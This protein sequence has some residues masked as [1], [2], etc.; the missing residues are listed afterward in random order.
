MLSFRVFA[1]CQPDWSHRPPAVASTRRGVRISPAPNL[2]GS[3]IGA[4]FPASQRPSIH[5]T[6]FLSIASGLFCTMGACNPFPFN[7]LRT[8]SIA[9][10]VC[11]PASPHLHRA[12]T[13][14]SCS[15]KSFRYWR[16]DPV[17]GGG[18]GVSSSTSTSARQQLACAT[19][20]GRRREGYRRGR[21]IH[22]GAS[23]LGDRPFRFRSGNS[24]SSR[25]CPFRG[26]N[27]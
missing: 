11:T 26:R 20:P 4:G 3:T 27:P 24:W 16:F 1:R 8:L 13:S 17:G 7:C 2:S 25:R 18:G 9:M 21:N 14:F 19:N 5:S 6:L 22:S 10:G 15:Q 23:K 12:S